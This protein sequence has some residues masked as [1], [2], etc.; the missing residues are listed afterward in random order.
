MALAL[1]H[2]MF[3]ALALLLQLCKCFVEFCFG[4]VI[5]L[6]PVDTDTLNETERQNHTVNERQS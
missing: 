4:F 6:R 5:L 1:L 2:D 3:M